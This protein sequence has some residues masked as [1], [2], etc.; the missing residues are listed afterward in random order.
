MTDEQKLETKSSVDIIVDTAMEIKTLK[1]KR[2][3]K[4]G[5]VRIRKK[6]LELSKLCNGL[7]KTCLA[8]KRAM[9]TKTRVPKVE[10][11]Q[12]KDDEVDKVDK[13]PPLKRSV[14]RR[15]R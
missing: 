6:A 13:P 14:T 2:P 8:E 11:E 12:T 7:R 15:R 9:P 5:C 3:T 10:S 1:G 4:V